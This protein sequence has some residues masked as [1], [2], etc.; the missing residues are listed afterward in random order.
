MKEYKIK[1]EV[2]PMV[3]YELNTLDTNGVNSLIGIWG[4][5]VYV[6][7]SIYNSELKKVVWGWISTQTTSGHDL[8]DQYNSITQAVND[9]TTIGRVFTFEYQ[10]DSLRKLF[11]K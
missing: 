9:F 6:L 8:S 10:E 2:S 11:I 3:K 7:K 1:E 5:R 4:N